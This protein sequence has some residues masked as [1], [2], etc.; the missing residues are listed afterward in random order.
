[1]YIYNHGFFEGGGR[2]AFAPPCK[3]IAPPLESGNLLLYII[4]VLCNIVTMEC[5]TE[6]VVFACANVESS[7]Y[8]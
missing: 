8:G 6:V 2:G 1:M 3:L 7:K 5:S 4:R